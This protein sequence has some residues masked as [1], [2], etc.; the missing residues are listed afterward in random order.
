[1]CD[2]CDGSDEDGSLVTCENTCD[3]E[4]AASRK[5]LEESIQAYKTGSKIREE[6]I[7]D[8]TVKVKEGETS[9][10]SLDANLQRVEEEEARLEKRLKEEEVLEKKEQDEMKQTMILEISSILGIDKLQASEL[11]P[12]IVN[13]FKIFDV[14]DEDVPDLIQALQKDDVAAMRPAVNVH[15]NMESDVDGTGAMDPYG[16]YEDDYHDH[17]E[18]EDLDERP[19]IPEY[20]EAS[21][22]NSNR[23]VVY[24]AANCELLKHELDDRLEA[25]CELEV[26]DLQRFV[27]NFIVSRKATREAQLMFGFY[28]LKNSFVGSSE[29][30]SEHNGS[31]NRPVAA[32]P[33]ELT[34]MSGACSI[35]ES[36]KTVMAKNNFAD[37]KKKGAD[38]IRDAL[39][40]LRAKNADVKKQRREYEGLVSA[41]KDFEGLYEYLA[42]REQCFDKVD[43]QYTYTVCFGKDARQKDTNGGGSTLLG[44]FQNVA[45]GLQKISDS[46]NGYNMKMKF[47]RGQHCHAFGARSAEVLIKCGPANVLLEASEPSTCFYSFRM[48]SPVACNDDFA[49]SIGL[50]LEKA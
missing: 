42:L 8:V 4:A 28:M 14:I 46:K 17:F 15:I 43:G 2:C 24:T 37:H 27:V 16:D 31:D 30:V 26:K 38:E 41:S 6:Y 35:E 29:F 9:M 36:L 47:E 3:A 23:K 25:F 10:A 48:E 44:N 34:A 45:S 5:A 20:K 21:E 33:S 32:C 19:K 49:R 13:F 50:P 40:D 11:A 39:K 7:R 1:M 22:T 18:E 12:L